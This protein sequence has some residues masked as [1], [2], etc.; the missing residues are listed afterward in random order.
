MENYRFCYQMNQFNGE[1]LPCTLAQFNGECLPCTLAQFKN[2]VSSDN[3]MWRISTRQEVEQ[4]LET[5]ASLDKF[6]NNSSFK[7][8][9]ERPRAGETASRCWMLKETQSCSEA[10]SRRTS[11]N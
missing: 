8:F 3:V 11:R 10:A 2:I 7:K 1:C 9:C 5:G 6:I 4:A